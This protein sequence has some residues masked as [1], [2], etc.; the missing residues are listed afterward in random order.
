M[1][2]RTGIY[3]TEIEETHLHIVDASSNAAAATPT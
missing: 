2:R 3:D 1:K